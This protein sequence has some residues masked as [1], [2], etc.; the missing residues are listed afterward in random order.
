MN[1]ERVRPVQYTVKQQGAVLCNEAY[2]VYESA[3][4]TC[5][6]LDL[7]SKYAE[8]AASCGHGVMLDASDRT[9][10]L[11]PDHPREDVTW[12]DFDLPSGSW[13]FFSGGVSRYTFNAV[14]LKD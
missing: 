11:S 9:L 14:F 10:H 4:C 5:I 1:D 3:D 2:T 7:R 12:I 8:L 6:Q 13:T